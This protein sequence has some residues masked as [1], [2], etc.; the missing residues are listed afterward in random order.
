MSIIDLRDGFWPMLDGRIS[1]PISSY[2][3]GN[4]EEMP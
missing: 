4:P 2:S 1:A 3:S